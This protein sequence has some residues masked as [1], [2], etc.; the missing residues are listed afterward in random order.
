MPA[1]PGA[2]TDSARGIMGD[3]TVMFRAV[4]GWGTLL[5]GWRLGD[6][7]GV[8]ADSRDRIHVLTRDD[9]PVIVLDRDGGFL[10]SWG[11]GDLACPHGIF[12]DEE[13]LVYVADNTDH[14][15]RVF[16]AD[17]RPVRVLGTPG[18]PQ[19]TGW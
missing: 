15:V 1:H 12:I 17:G 18:A 6:V 5:E 16:D 9:H 4:P 7:A 3:A 8:A 19:D 2:D 13:D 10:F 11:E 14:T